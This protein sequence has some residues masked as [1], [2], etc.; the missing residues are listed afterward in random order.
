[1]ELHIADLSTPG[2]LIIYTKAI[3]KQVLL[4]PNH[5]LVFKKRETGKKA[6]GTLFSKL[7]PFVVKKSVGGVDFKVLSHEAA[8]LD[9]LLLQNNGG[10]LDNYLVVKFLKK[11]Q[12]VLQR[13]ILGKLV[14]LRYISSI[15][16]LREIA[17]AQGYEALYQDCVSIIRDE[18]AG[19]FLTSKK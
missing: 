9:M 8:L 4:S 16:R 18:G 6:V 10:V 15:N 19:C 14:E 7:L 13:S 12:S 11:Y 3:S 1:M 2:T 5:K 17:K